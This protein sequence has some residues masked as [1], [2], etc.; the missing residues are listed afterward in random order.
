VAAIAVGA[1][2]L[3]NL[4]HSRVDEDA[5][6][7]AE[8]TPATELITASEGV[9]GHEAPDS[10]SPAAVMFG[11]GVSLAVTGRVSRA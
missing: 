1:L 9:I 10:E 11:A 2:L 4:Q 5:Y 7:V 8:F 3:S 6:T